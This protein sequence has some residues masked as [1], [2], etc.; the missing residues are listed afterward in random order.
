[1]RNDIVTTIRQSVEKAHLHGETR[2]C[3]Y[4]I[5]PKE[6]TPERVE[7][8]R[9]FLD[10]LLCEP[11]D[12]Y[13]TKPTPDEMPAGARK[14]FW[15]ATQ[16][17][18]KPSLG[19]VQSYF[20]LYWEILVEV[21]LNYEMI[22]TRVVDRLAWALEKGTRKIRLVLVSPTDC[23][24]PEHFEHRPNML[25]S[26]LRLKGKLHPVMPTRDQLPL[27][28]QHAIKVA[29]NLGCSVEIVGFESENSA[30]D[31]TFYW[32]LSTTLPESLNS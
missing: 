26:L 4:T 14:T 11:G 28:A 10:I 3:V 19:A 21:P 13:R 6:C 7:Y 12:L 8:R 32:A 2:T 20:S 30:G 31:S 5:F 29:E 1:M 15:V 25:Q 27:D 9:N 24:Q 16:L 17:G 23:N 22:K 18:L